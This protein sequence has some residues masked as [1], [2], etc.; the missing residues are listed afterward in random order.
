MALGLFNISEAN[1]IAIHMCA[2]LAAGDGHYSSSKTIS[3]SLGFSRDHSAKVLQ[4]LVR[5]GIVETSRGP[6]G[7]AKL[8]R[9]PSEISLLDVI[10]SSGA[11]SQEG[12]CLLRPEI[13]CGK[14]CML[15]MML[16]NENTKMLDRFRKTTIADIVKSLKRE[17]IRLATEKPVKKPAATDKRK[18][19][20]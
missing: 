4:Q 9:S 15:G 14:G 17:N 18:S 3:E 10:S 8:V 6:S 11:A 12:R 16:K 20:K 5:A 13:C 2:W 1:S 7:G 19:T